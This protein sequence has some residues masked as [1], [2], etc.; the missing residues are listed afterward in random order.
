[1]AAILSR[2]QCVMFWDKSCLAVDHMG[3]IDDIEDRCA[4]NIESNDV[5]VH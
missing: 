1:M 4:P 3:I 5:P 2:P